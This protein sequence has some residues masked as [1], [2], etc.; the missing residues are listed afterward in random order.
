MTSSS[1]RVVLTGMGVL[2]PIGLELDS[3]WQAL[4]QGQSGIRTIQSVDTSGLPI[5][6]A[7]EILDFDA[8]RYID[9]KERKSLKVMARTIQFAVSAAQLALDDACI[10]KTK[11]DPTR[12]GVE[13]GSG[14]IATELEELA[15]AS[16]LCA[17]CQPGAV[18]LAKWGEHGLATMPPLWMLKYLPNMLACHVS[19]LHNAQGP[20]NT[21]TE[22]DVASLL[23]LGEAYR[24]LKRDQADFFVVGGAD[25]KINPLSLVR[26]CL[27]QKLSKRNDEPEKAC[28][29]FDKNRDGTV[30]GEGASVLALEELEHAQRRGARIY[31]E[32]VGFGA[33]YDRGKTGAGLARAMQTALREAGIGPDQVDHVSAHSAGSIEV[34]AWEARGIQQA[35][36]DAEPPV[37]ALASYI[38]N[39]G[40]ASGLT[41]LAASLLALRHGSLPPT[42]NYEEPDPACPITVAAREPRPIRKPYVVKLSFTD[43]GHCGAAV[44]RRWD[45]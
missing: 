1:R 4:L 23:A 43:M 27:F 2:S 11:L 41:E 33:A 44:L 35:F 36:G 19:I 18:E 32:V 16:V 13:F 3:F 31:A 26:Q 25:S 15:P 21:I 39:L 34:D 37:F 20:N 17:N 12:F 9:K 6:F 29:P 45:D 22:S 10:D 14:L 7:G 28:R 40:A 38:G 30:I 24:I 8:K 42:L 5:H